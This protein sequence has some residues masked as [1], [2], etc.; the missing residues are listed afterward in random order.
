MHPG[1]DS[2]HVIDLGLE[3]SMLDDQSPSQIP[4]LSTHHDL[5]EESTANENSFQQ[6]ERERAP[7]LSRSSLRSLLA[8]G[9][10]QQQTERYR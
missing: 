9:N 6:V 7:V 8:D 1:E 10:D 5:K 4:F 2:G 3:G